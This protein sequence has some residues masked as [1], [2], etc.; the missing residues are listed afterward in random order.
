MFVF[1]LV[2]LILLLGCIILFR[3]DNVGCGSSFVILRYDFGCIIY[4]C[5]FAVV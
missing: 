2:G 5:F 3:F 1:L 4:D